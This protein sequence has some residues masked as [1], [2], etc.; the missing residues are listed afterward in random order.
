MT[1]P[2]PAF[3]SPSEWAAVSPEVLGELFDAALLEGLVSS[4]TPDIEALFQDLTP[5]D[6]KPAAGAIAPEQWQQLQAQHQQITQ[7]LK[8]TLTYLAKVKALAYQ[9]QAVASEFVP[10]PKYRRRQPPPP[11]PLEYLTAELL[12]AIAHTQASL[13]PVYEPLH[14][15]G[16]TLNGT[17]TP[18]ISEFPLE[19]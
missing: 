15:L 11:H 10:T 7:H 6:L 9:L 12:R 14:Q 16:E 18:Q 13:E 3:S 17:S 4:E 1:A 2:D 5:L 8:E 19:P